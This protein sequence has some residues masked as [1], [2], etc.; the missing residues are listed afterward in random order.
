M[1]NGTPTAAGTASFTVNVT[2]TPGTTLT[3]SYTLKVNRALGIAPATLATA[4]IGAATNQTITVSGGTRPY[5]TFNISAF[6]GGTTGL[7]IASLAIDAAAGTIVLS[8]TPTARGTAKFRV[9][10]TDS[11]GAVL[12]KHYT[13]TVGKTAT[14]VT[15]TG[16]TGSLLPGEDLKLGVVVG[17]K[18]AAVA[19][20]AASQAAAP[21]ES[22]APALPTGTVTFKDGTTSI[23]TVRLTNGQASFQHAALTIGTHAISAFYE[24]TPTF[25]ASRSTINVIVDPKVGPEFRVNTRVA[26]SQESPSIARLADGGFVIVWQSNLQ[27]GSSWGIYGQ[28]Y[29]LP[30]HPKTANSASIRPGLGRRPS[31][32]SRAWPEAASSSAGR[33]RIREERISACARSVSVRMAARSAKSSSSAQR[34]AVSPR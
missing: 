16:P 7:T 29:D 32:P 23:G 14:A 1:L 28:R 8:G 5:T 6:S 17:V 34:P 31:P 10:V 24:G 20:G 3:E 13:L 9:N 33:P 19:G 27:D 15:I 30:A 18:S 26:D 22:A 25:A 12:T 21:D 4:S 11:A 2:D